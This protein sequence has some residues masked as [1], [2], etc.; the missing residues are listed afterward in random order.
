MKVLQ[1]KRPSSEIARLFVQHKAQHGVLEFV[2]FDRP[3][4]C[5]SEPELHRQAALAAL[6]V[7]AAWNE[8]YFQQ[9]HVIR[10]FVTYGLDAEK[11]FCVVTEPDRACGREIPV[12]DFVGPFYDFSSRR[13]FLNG[14]SENHLNDYFL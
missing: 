10:W 13:L 6:R 2:L 7:L 14:L 9:E 8:Q 4:P 5:P 3:R 1:E 12:S 11:R